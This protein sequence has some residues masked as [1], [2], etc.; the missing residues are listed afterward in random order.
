MGK[1]TRSG[2]CRICRTEGPLSFEHGP[3]R[4]AFNDRP[5]IRVKGRR[6][7]GMDQ[8]ELFSEKGPVDQRGAGAYTLCQRCNNDTGRWYGPAYAEWA[9]QGMHLVQHAAD[10]LSLYHLFHIFPLRVIKQVFCMFFSANSS[11]LG[12]RH[13]DLARFVLNKQNRDHRY[14]DPLLRVFAYFNAAP[15][16]RQ[17]G[18]S[19]RLDISK[20]VCHSFSEITFPPFG[21]LL[22]VDGKTP[23]DRLTDISY[24][25]RYS[26]DDWTDVALRLPV[27]HLSTFVPGDF[28][29]RA[30]V[31]KD[32]REQTQ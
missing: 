28:R 31:L 13:G 9:Y 27:F 3:P 23:H 26:Y 17:S 4:S 19:G 18:I 21:Y 8:D 12:K 16:S 14:A 25:S 32:R 22:S 11:G 30:E 7:F 2:I 24:F 20:R 5:M 29:S 15:V 10:A 1:R 6:L